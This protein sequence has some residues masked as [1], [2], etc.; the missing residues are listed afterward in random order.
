MY[1]YDASVRLDT[2]R[3]GHTDGQTDRRHYDTNSLQVK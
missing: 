1:M 3:Y 2:R